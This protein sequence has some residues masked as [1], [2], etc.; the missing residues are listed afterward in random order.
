[1]QLSMLFFYPRATLIIS[2]R[3]LEIDS[4]ISAVHF[5]NLSGTLIAV[6]MYESCCNEY[7][8]PIWSDRVS[9]A[10]DFAVRLLLVETENDKEMSRSHIRLESQ[11]LSQRMSQLKHFEVDVL[12]CGAI[13]RMLAEMVKASGIEVLPY[14]T[15]SIDDILRALDLEIWL[16]FRK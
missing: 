9:I 6:Y 16:L 5:G 11:P 13:S 8:I 4:Y 2:I 12:V 14:V 10:F 15:G 7:T 1:M 3:P